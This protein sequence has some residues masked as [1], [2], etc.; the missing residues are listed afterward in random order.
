VYFALAWAAYFYVFVANRTTDLEVGLGAAGFAA[1]IS[2]P[3]A[4]LLNRTPPISWVYGMAAAKVPFE[5]LPG[6][7]F[8]VGLKE[9]VLKALPILLLAFWTD[10]IKKPLDGIFYGALCGLGFAVAEGTRYVSAAHNTGW[11]IYQTLL[12]TTTLPF[13]HATWSAISGYF[14]ALAMV[15]KH[16]RAALCLIGIAVATVLHGCYDFAAAGTIGVGIA[17]FVYLLFISYIDRSQDMVHALEQAERAHATDGRISTGV[18][19]AEMPAGASESIL[20]H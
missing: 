20:T 19:P 15:N 8:G 2:F 7:V 1:L 18:I 14:I 11:V 12:R 17:A 6:F 5:R 13:L 10:R 9:E 16:R 4:L 3:I